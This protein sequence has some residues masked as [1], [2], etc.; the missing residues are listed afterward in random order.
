MPA[1]HID[2]RA[3]RGLHSMQPCRCE[4]VGCQ[5]QK[6]PR[7]SFGTSGKGQTG[8]SKHPGPCD[9]CA[10]ALATS[11]GADPECVRPGPGS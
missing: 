4:K 9:R 6:A 8:S 10:T 5:D 2:G 3:G 1:A 11:Q 7:V